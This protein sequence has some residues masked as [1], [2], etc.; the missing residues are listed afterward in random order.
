MTDLCAGIL[1]G[2][3]IGWVWGL[4]MNKNYKPE[5]PYEPRLGYRYAWIR[6]AWRLERID[7]DGIWR[8]YEGTEMNYTDKIQDL[9]R[10]LGVQKQELL[11]LT[12][13]YIDL[14]NNYNK[15]VFTMEERQRIAT[16]LHDGRGSTTILT[17]KYEQLK[18]DNDQLLRDNKQAY[19]A[20]DE[21]AEMIQSLQAKQDK[22]YPFHGF[23][24]P[25]NDARVLVACRFTHK[26][27]NNTELM[28]KSAVFDG[29]RYIIDGEEM[30]KPYW[31]CDIIAWREMPEFPADKVK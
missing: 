30:F 16:P 1:I 22:W 21:R 25:V 23:S 24:Q 6:D 14:N 19:K 3:F 18:R 27:Y 2:M 29:K 11:E 8:E 20:L 9:F 13:K 17:K 5:K 10:A 12:K 31:N 15:L 26:F 7:N 28:I 4:E